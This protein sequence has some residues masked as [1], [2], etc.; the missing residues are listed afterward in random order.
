MLNTTCFGQNA[1]VEAQPGHFPID[2]AAGRLKIDTG[3]FQ[4]SPDVFAVGACDRLVHGG[5]VPCA[6]RLCCRQTAGELNSR[7]MTRL[8]RP[9]VY[10]I[11]N[12][13]QPH[14]TAP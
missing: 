13:P 7:A 4:Q 14:A 12:R 5:F 10:H 6:S 9:G 8:I 11:A 3:P 1:F 2:E